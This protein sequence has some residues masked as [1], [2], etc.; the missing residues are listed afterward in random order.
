MKNHSFEW[1]FHLLT[2]Q[3]HVLID[4]Y[5]RVIIALFMVS[6]TDVIFY[7]FIFLALYVQ[8]F[9]LVT[10]LEKRQTLKKEFLKPVYFP[11]VTFIVPCY[12]EENTV[13]GT[14]ESIKKIEY[15]KNKISIIV[16]NDGSKDSTWNVLQQY[17][18]DASILLL[19]KENGGKHSALNIALPYVET[20][21]VCSFDAD[22]AI[23]PDALAN[24]MMYF[25]ND[26]NL[27]AL[28]GAVLIEE[29]KT[30]VQRAQSIEY[31]MFS[32][33]KKVLGLLGGVLV[34]PGAFSVF[35]K[36]ALIDVGGYRHAHLLEDLE[37]TYRLQ[38][39][40]KKVSHSHNAF[41]Y[42]KGP[43]SLKALFKQRLRWSYG[44]INNTYDYKNAILNKKY[45]NFG[46]FTLPM[47]I[48]AYPAILQVFVLFWYNA[49]HFLNR[50]YIEY[51]VLGT[52]SL[53]PSFSLDF[54]FVDTTV[55]TI[56]TIL[57]FGSIFLGIYLGKKVSN[58]SRVS[59]RSI[60]WFVV[61][62]S[63][64]VPVWTLKALYNTIFGKTTVWGK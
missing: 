57:L 34:V 22:T 62:Y 63:M 25:Y 10:Y 21:Y 20:E 28:G 39:A 36:Q 4:I 23:V 53:I 1:V 31:Q 61:V 7:T 40:G 11:P 26:K 13:I 35:K 5:I 52:E 19:N 43:S 44:Y 12:N 15:P 42:T 41:V 47:T 18:N 14:I 6:P 60:F 50:K 49:I 32:Y 3:Q 59:L 46:L 55:S 8:V 54:F 58:I 45:G 64:M 29:P 56:L 24:A 37:L 38:T 2:D 27:D 9:F 17:K 48:I 33:T 16:V 30:I 51:Q